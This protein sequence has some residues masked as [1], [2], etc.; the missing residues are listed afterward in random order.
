MNTHNEELRGQSFKD[1]AYKNVTNK[2]N[3]V[4]QGT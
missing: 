3:G 1:I 4:F 2:N